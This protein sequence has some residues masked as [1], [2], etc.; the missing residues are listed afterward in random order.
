MEIF[1]DTAK[2]EEIRQAVA[3][4]I[5]SGVTTNPSLMMRAG[6]GDYQEVTQE[7]CSLVQG[8]ISAEVVSED[9]TGM[10][11]EAR[12]IAQWSPHVLIK[13][14]ITEEGLKAIH[15]IS[16]L[17]VDPDT[18]CNG[19]PWFGKCDT[20][21]EKARELAALWGVRTNCTLVF[22]ANQALLAALAGATF[23]SPFV[24]RLDDAGHDGMQIVADIVNI[25]DTYD[26]DTRVLAAS[27]RHPL[28]ITQA[29]LAGADIATVPFAVLQ[30]AIHHPLTDV[31]VRRFLE[32]WA[33]VQA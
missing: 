14:P 4:G 3:W 18:L 28:H 16:A 32:D 26:I 10:V 19:C 20:P 31:G 21:I 33:Q 13:V 30:K 23:V 7:I 1:L 8:P 12:R 6:R 9:A 11:E 29:A 25:F 5:V 15:A 24:G 27:I 22:S 17:E 2:V